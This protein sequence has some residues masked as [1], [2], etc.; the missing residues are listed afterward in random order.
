MK[1]TESLVS[2]L[3]IELQQI[4]QWTLNLH[5]LQLEVTAAQIAMKEEILLLKLIR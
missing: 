2:L 5:Q 1:I 4:V 3:V